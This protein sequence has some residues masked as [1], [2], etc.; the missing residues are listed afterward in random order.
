M[1]EMFRHRA[2]TKEEFF[3][4]RKQKSAPQRQLW[5]QFDALE[6]GSGWTETDITRPQVLIEDTYGDSHPGS[7]HLKALSRQAAMGVL[8]SGGY[9]A[10]YHVTTA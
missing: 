3:V 5:A 9:P 6:M 8:Q 1:M 2:G 7:V 10:H 4:N